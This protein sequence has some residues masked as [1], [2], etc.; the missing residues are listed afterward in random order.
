MRGSVPL[1]WEQPGV[2]VGSHKVKLSRGSDLS[3]SAFEKH[4]ELLTRDYGNVVILNLLG[5]NLVGSKEGEAQLSTAYQEQQTRS[6]Y[7]GMTHHLWDFH[8]EGGSKHLDKLWSVLGADLGSCGHFCSV[9][10]SVSSSQRSVVRVNCMDCLDRSNVTQAWIGHRMLGSMLTSLMGPEVKENTV[11][12]L[13]DMFHQMWV[14]NGN[15]LSKLYAGT[16]ALS[17]GGSKLLDGARSAARTIQNNLLDKDK[18]EAFDILVLGSI[19]QSDFRDRAGLVLPRH[20]LNAPAAF[21]QSI[22]E[23]WSQYSKH[24]PY[25]IAVGK[26]SLMQD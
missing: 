26:L 7:L 20:L 4:F 13:R 3:K 5:I 14:N 8:A 12:R 10:G 11:A 9:Q 23:K 6:R 21:Q 2:N 1:F 16:G 19:K 24:C 25:R 15:S 18:Q 17:Q 22:C